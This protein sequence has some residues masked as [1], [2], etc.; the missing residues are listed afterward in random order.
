MSYITVPKVHVMKSICFT[1]LPK[2]TT[3]MNMLSKRIISY[4]EICYLKATRCSAHHC[5]NFLSYEITFGY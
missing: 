2:C 1:N 4:P 3:Q 5:Y